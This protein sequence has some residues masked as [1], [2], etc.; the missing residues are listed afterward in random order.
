MEYELQYDVFTFE[1]QC[2]DSL[3][4]AILTSLSS[5][6]SPSHEV[7]PSVPSS[8]SLEL[9][10]FLNMLKYAFLG[11]NETFSV[12]LANDLNSNQE[13]QVVDL[14]SE[15]KEALHWTLGDI[16]GINPTIVQH[17][18]HLQDN[19]EPY[20]DRKRRLNPTL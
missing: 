1:E 17:R 15:S 3:H 9:K 16:H 13:T 20:Q 5:I 14:L 18:I 7:L 11:P 10:P 2:D 6:P 8:S 12:I 19:A 4:T